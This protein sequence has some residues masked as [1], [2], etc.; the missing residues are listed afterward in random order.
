MNS[1]TSNANADSNSQNAFREK[2]LSQDREILKDDHAEFAQ[3][4]SAMM[5][6]ATFRDPTGR[7]KA[8]ELIGAK[9]N[10]ISAIAYRALGY[11][12]EPDVNTKLSE[13]LKSPDSSAQQGALDAL[14]WNPT[15]GSGREEILKDHFDSTK[16]MQGSTYTSSP[17]AMRVIGALYR[18]SKDDSAQN[19]YLAQITDVLKNSKNE[20]SKRAAAQ[21]YLQLAPKNAPAR[22]LAESALKTPIPHK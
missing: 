5:R 15:A 8:L 20:L 3:V 10:K 14:T 2:L 21:T 16:K 4:A 12:D 11:Y 18:I 17:E 1:S 19:E 7:A 22:E 9:D 13:L 6:L